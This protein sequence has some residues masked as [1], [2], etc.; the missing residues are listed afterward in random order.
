MRAANSWTT[1]ALDRLSQGPCGYHGGSS[2][3]AEPTALATIALLAAGRCRAAGNNLR[4]LANVQASSGQVPPLKE[5]NQPGWP[6]AWST[7]AAVLERRNSATVDEAAQALTDAVAKFD[8]QT[9]T[10][11]LLA[12]KGNTLSPS[13]EYGHDVQLVGWPWVIGTHS[14]Q[15][16]TATAVLALK[17]LG[18]SAHNRTREGVRLLVDRLLTTGGCNYGNTVVLGQRLRPHIEPTGIALLALAGEDIDDPRIERSLQFLMSA[19]RDDTTPISLSYGLLGLAA[20]GRELPDA[21][22]WLEI[23]YRR[24]TKRKVSPLAL[25]LLLL[26]GEGED[27]PLVTLTKFQGF[28][29]LGVPTK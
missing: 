29:L 13:P 16:P 24:T 11:W 18:L 10:N 7:I 4:W 22:H 1:D 23:A 21:S 3:A 12:A 9:A 27:S 2:P 28:Q 15:E 5:L 17:A 20:H 6:T 26:A 8:L 14:W 19:L 25:A